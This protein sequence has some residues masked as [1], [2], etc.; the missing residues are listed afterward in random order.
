MKKYLLKNGEQLTIR[1]AVKEDAKNLIEYVKQVGTESD[2]LSFGKGEFNISLA[3]EEKM[4]EAHLATDNA[5]YLVAEINGKLV[6]SLNFSGGK[7]PRTKHFGEFGVSVIKSHWNLGIG[8]KL[9]SYMIEWAK[10][11]GV[12]RKINLKVRAD[13][14]H[15]IHLYEKMGFKQEGIISRFFYLH[16]RFYDVIE[17]GLEID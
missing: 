17:M 3:D 7:R 14:Q 10:E 12:I 2:F 13:H 6:G 9:I 15:G 8:E 11:S 1:E 5:I 4:L 16:E